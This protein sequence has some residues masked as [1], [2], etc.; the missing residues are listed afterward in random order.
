MRRRKKGGPQ[1]FA[2]SESELVGDDDAQLLA[3]L[4]RRPNLPSA[5]DAEAE[6]QAL[7]YVRARGLRL[8]PW[9][10]ERKA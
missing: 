8:P 3:Q 1:V 2:F 4:Q 10:W 7:N 6:R 9:E 5:A